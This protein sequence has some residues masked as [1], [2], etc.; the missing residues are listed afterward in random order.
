MSSPDPKILLHQLHW[1]YA[2]QKFDPSRQIPLE[3]WSA[4]EQA[5]VLTPS[6]Y[7]LQP[8]KFL[9]VDGPNRRAELR[10][11]SWNQTQ[12]TDASHFVVFAYKPALTAADVE[13]Y[14][15]RMAEVRSLPAGSLSNF[16]KL[17]LNFVQTTPPE[18][19]C[20]W[21]QHQT[22][23][24]LGNFLTSAAVL[25]IDTCPMEGIDPAQY[26]KILG[27]SEEGFTTSCAAAAGFRAANDRYASATK[28]RFPLPEVVKHL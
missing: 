1:R 14:I 5:L 24:A 16:Q 25:G 4:L 22:Y 23:I 13:H 10:A 15:A 17:L 18:E 27:L 6:S 7:G 11:V 3:T 2:V 9:V 20:R 28:V 12:V 21:A 8:W 26:D 19:L